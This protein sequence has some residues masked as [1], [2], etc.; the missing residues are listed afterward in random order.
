MKS[1]GYLSA[2][3]LA[4]Q[5]PPHAT[6][7]QAAPV[8]GAPLPVLQPPMPQIPIVVP[9]TTVDERPQPQPVDEGAGDGPTEN[10]Y[11]DEP[12]QEDLQEIVQEPGKLMYCNLKL[13]KYF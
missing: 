3:K 8:M 13:F 7:T 1:F 2:F 12:V 6:S 11:P 9:I 5:V 4:A 10:I